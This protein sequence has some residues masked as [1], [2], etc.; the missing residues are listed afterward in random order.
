MPAKILKCY[1][2]ASKPGEMPCGKVENDS[3]CFGALGLGAQL[4]VRTFK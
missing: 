4:F 3:K 2:K 1:G